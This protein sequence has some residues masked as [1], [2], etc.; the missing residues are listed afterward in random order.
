MTHAAKKGIIIRGN[1]HVKCCGIESQWRSW[2][3]LP[4]W[5]LTVSVSA[6]VFL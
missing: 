5:P 2:H 4:A 6:A 3:V 1:M